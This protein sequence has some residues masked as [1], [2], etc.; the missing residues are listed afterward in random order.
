L[1]PITAALVGGLV[2]ATPDEVV[3]AALPKMVFFAEFVAAALPNNVLFAELVVDVSTGPAVV[4]VFV[5]GLNHRIRTFDFYHNCITYSVATPVDVTSSP[6]PGP[7]FGPQF[8]SHCSE[9]KKGF[10]SSHISL[11]NCTQ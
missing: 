5:A 9:S 10:A 11:K 7:A 6:T 2:E 4:A 1:D 3:E 8:S